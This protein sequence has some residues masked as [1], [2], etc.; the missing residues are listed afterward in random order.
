MNFTW[1]NKFG[2]RIHNEVVGIFPEMNVPVLP[3]QQLRGGPTFWA[4][5][6][7]AARRSIDLAFPAQGTE[8]PRRAVD[9]D[10]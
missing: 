4:P 9:I 7:S 5:V 1:T 6:C 8:L 2:I 10:W 3:L